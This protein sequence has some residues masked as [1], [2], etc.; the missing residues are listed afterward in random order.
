MILVC[1]NFPK[2][3]GGM[4]E[5]I[6]QRVVIFEFLNQFRGT[7][8]MNSNLLNEILADPQEM[9]WLIYNGI[10]AYE[11]MITEGGDFIGRVDSKKARILLN[12]HTDP[13]SFVLPKLVNYDEDKSSEDPIVANELNDLIQY[14]AKN[15]GL[16]I[17]LNRKG[18]ISPKKLIST[19]RYQFDLNHEWTSKL[20]SVKGYENSVTIYLNLCKTPE[21]DTWLEKMNKSNAS[22]K[23]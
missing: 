3:E 22:D 6:V 13:I 20:A 21:Y 2:F 5:A 19:I 9:E 17:S 18:M 12:K 11:K 14:V 4:E 7:D 23:K 15:E 16:A 8:K 1:N 10:K